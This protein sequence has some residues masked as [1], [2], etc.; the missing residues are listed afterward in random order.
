MSEKNIR[1]GVI[2]RDDQTLAIYQSRIISF[3]LR[4]YCF[5]LLGLDFIVI[6]LSGLNKN[7]FLQKAWYMIAAPF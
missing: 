4:I 7:D 6:V 2:V 3:E 5:Y 1:A